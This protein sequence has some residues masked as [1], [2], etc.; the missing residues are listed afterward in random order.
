MKI[1]K[2]IPIHK[3]G[4]KDEFYNHRPISPLPLFSKI[5]EELFDNRLEKFIC[6]NNILSDCQFVFRTNRSSSMAIV[7]LRRK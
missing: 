1:A 4:A 2:V 7:N 5:I 6:K 3:T